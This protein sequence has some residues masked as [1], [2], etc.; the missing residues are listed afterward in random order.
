MVSSAKMSTVVFGGI[1]SV[2]LL[3]KIRKSSGARTDPVAHRE[4]ETGKR[5]T[6]CQ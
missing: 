3:M 5:N 1:V 6:L 4:R 2:R